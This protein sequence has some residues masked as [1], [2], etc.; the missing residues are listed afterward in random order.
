MTWSVWQTGGRRH[1]FLHLVFQGSEADARTRFESIR[2]GLRAGGVQLRDMQ[3]NT[4]EN[5][6]IPRPGLF[7]PRFHDLAQRTPEDA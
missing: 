6:M 3:G 1:T 7:G 2:V 5:F 4:V